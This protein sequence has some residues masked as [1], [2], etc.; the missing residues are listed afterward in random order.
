MHK[1]KFC[2]GIKSI[3]FLV[4]SEVVTKW[5]RQTTYITCKTIS[6]NLICCFPLTGCTSLITKMMRDENYRGLARDWKVTILQNV[7]FSS[8]IHGETNTELLQSIF[9]L[10]FSILLGEKK[11]K[12]TSMRVFGFVSFLK[13]YINM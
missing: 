10:R 9:F 3:T 12:W 8:V 7:P 4:N 5:G 6:G 1:T 11:C 13:G 2:F